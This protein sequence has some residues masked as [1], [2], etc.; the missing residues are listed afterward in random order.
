MAQ[1]KKATRTRTLESTQAVP[2]GECWRASKKAV[3]R[4]V[5][6]K[7]AKKKKA[8]FKDVD[9][10]DEEKA[11]TILAQRVEALSADIDARVYVLVD[12]FRDQ[13]ERLGSHI[14]EETSNLSADLEDRI[15]NITAR[16]EHEDS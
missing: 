6:K 13:L 14:Y 16:R 9:L 3:R 7:A 15:D 12:E 10:I 5:Y 2:C 4:K 1:R 8:R 11:L